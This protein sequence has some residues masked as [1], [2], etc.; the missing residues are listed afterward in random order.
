[1]RKQ[2]KGKNGLI[3]TLANDGMYYPNISMP[4]GTDYDIGRFGRIRGRYLKENKNNYY[5]AL[6]ISGELNQNLYDTNIECENMIEV[7]TDRLLKKQ[8]VTEQLKTTDQ[9]EW[10][11]QVNNIRHIAEEFVVRELI[12]T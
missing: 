3:Y 7:M 11:R 10:I 4:K 1:M 6:L 2:I 8:G 12:F 5:T 9:M